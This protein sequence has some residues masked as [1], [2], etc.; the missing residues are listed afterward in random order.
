MDLLGVTLAQ[1]DAHYKKY[2]ASPTDFVNN[3]TEDC[4]SHSETSAMIAKDSE[5]LGL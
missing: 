5:G 4:D 3:E 2:S 1:L